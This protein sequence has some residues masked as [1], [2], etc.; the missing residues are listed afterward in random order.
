VQFLARLLGRCRF[1]CAKEKGDVFERLVQLFLLTK[2]KYK[3]EL[4][5]VWLARSEIPTKVR[6]RLC[7][8]FTDE[9]IDLIAQTRDGKFWAI[10]ALNSKPIPRGLRPIKGLRHS[11]ILLSFIA[12]RSLWRSLRTLRRDPSVN[13]AYSV[14]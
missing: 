6:K 2:P 13:E 9:G 8:P 1:S 3:T 11:A 12:K 5:A 7:L 10:Q 4:S 14:I